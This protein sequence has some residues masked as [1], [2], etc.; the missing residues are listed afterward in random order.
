MVMHYFKNL[1]L[2]RTVAR[3]LF[4]R[5]VY[6]KAMRSRG[7]GVL[8]HPLIHA[9]GSVFHCIIKLITSDLLM[10]HMLTVQ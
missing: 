6:S 9:R 5:K 3:M 8:L 1:E 2:K 10:L 7:A 4:F